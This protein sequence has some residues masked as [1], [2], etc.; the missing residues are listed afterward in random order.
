MKS[1]RIAN[2]IGSNA[3]KRFRERFALNSREEREEGKSNIFG[4]VYTTIREE[5]LSGRSLG[6]SVYRT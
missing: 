1:S 2:K 3:V 6:S 4:R 5:D